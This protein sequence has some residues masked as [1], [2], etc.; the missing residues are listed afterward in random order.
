[1]ENPIHQVMLALLKE[2]LQLNDGGTA[3]VERCLYIDMGL[4]HKRAMLNCV[5]IN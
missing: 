2:L 1:M 4:D 5:S 3:G